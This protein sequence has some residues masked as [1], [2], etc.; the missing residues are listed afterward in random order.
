M[1]APRRHGIP[2]APLPPP[3]GGGLAGPDRHHAPGRAGRA[4]LVRGTEPD[5]HPRR[6]R[7]RGSRPVADRHGA[8]V[9]AAAELGCGRADHGLV[10][11]PDRPDRA[12][13]H[14]T[15]R[16]RRAG[17]LGAHPPGHPAVRHHA[18]GRG[19]AAG[20]R[21]CR[22]PRRR[23]VTGTGPDA[24]PVVLLPPSKGKA[25]G[26]D[27]APYGDVVERGPLGAARGQVLDA[28][29][30]AADQLEDARLARIA[31]VGGQDVAATRREL[32]ALADAPTLPA[33]QRYTGVVHGNAGL[34][35]LSPED[36]DVEVLVLSA[37]LGVVGLADPVPAYRLELAASLPPLGGLATFWRDAL[38]A[39][40]AGRLAGRQVLDL[41]PAA[42]GR[43]VAPSV[44]DSAE[45]VTIVFVSP[46]GR[47][48]NAARTKVA[49][50]RVVAQL[51]GAGQPARLE[52]APGSLAGWLEPGEGWQLGVRD[53]STLVAVYLG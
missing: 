12:R 5:R 4:G 27:G 37:L 9:V 43:A 19:A 20:P 7:A 52:L 48:A 40:L 44:R 11:R 10:G 31:G 1:D 29:V 22:P 33:G 36:S 41:L 42:H 26:G 53:R 18:G 8:R 14:R 3:G 47:A 6:C 45:V 35:R 24:R 2:H 49:K 28:A 39:D 32:A 13:L 15:A 17:L 34:A 23:T 25:A 30:A 21:G 38:A 50:G 46:D 51:A 16:R